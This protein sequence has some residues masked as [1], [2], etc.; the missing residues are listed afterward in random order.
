[1]EVEVNEIG[2]M[3]DDDMEGKRRK[4][5]ESEREKEEE[6][7]QDEIEMN[8]RMKEWKLQ[9]TDENVGEIG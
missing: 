4:K 3:A 7:E 6:E 9:R 8:K 2:R 5:K 1:M